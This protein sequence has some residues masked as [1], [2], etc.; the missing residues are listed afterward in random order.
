MTT[1]IETIHDLHRILVEHPEW[2][3]EMRSVLLTKE[4]LELPER[5]AEYTRVTDGRLNRIEGD[6]VEIKGDI[7]EIKADV[8]EIKGDMRVMKDDMGIVKGI[9]LENRLFTRGL[10]QISRRLRMSHG[11]VIRMATWDA[12]S[13]EFNDIARNAYESGFFSEA[14]YDRLMD[15]DTVVRGRM[16]RASNPVYVAVEAT[17]SLSRQDIDKVC[18]S[19]ALIRRLF[20]DSDAYPL[21]Y[22]VNPNAV[23]EAEA[24]E[25]GVALLQTRID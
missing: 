23:L 20:P 10:A 22:Y 13:T 7:V 18:Q 12:N 25:R 14:E 8:V 21:L 9:V 5:F 17:F 16:V 2:L 6:I 3:N 24:E 11:R 15:T 1:T 4:L 19:A